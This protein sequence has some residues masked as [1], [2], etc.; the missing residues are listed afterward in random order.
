MYIDP[1]L[2]AWLQRIPEP[3]SPSQKDKMEKTATTFMVH[4]LLV[5]RWTLVQELIQF[6]EGTAQP[7]T[8]DEQ[9]QILDDLAFKKH[10]ND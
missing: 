1:E 3:D 7:M 8:V 6:N 10:T 9:K 5:G 2:L 4:G